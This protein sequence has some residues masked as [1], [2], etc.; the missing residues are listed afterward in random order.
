MLHL[1]LQNFYK[2]KEFKE[3]CFAFYNETCNDML[4]LIDNDLN[5]FRDLDNYC[6]PAPLWQQVIEWFRVKHGIFIEV[7]KSN[8][9]DNKFLYKIRKYNVNDKLVRAASYLLYST[10]E[11]TLEKAIEKAIE[12]I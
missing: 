10:F 8:F 12:L 1:K 4:Q 11:L 6:I 3:Q 5:N 2:K 9:K 7:T